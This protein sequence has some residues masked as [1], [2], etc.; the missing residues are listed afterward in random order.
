MFYR[1]LISKLK[2]GK[3]NKCTGVLDTGVCPFGPQNLLPVELKK[4]GLLPTSGK[5]D[6][7]LFS[8]I[9]VT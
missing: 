1:D 9:F 3:R 2:Q 7:R 8:W 5:K 4:R 6:L